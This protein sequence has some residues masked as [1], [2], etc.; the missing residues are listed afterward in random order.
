MKAFAGHTKTIVRPINRERVCGRCGAVYKTSSNNKNHCHIVPLSDYDKKVL[1]DFRAV[2]ARY[3]LKH[4]RIYQQLIGRKHLFF[5]QLAAGRHMA[6]GTKDRF[7]LILRRFIDDIQKGLYDF[8][9]TPKLWAF[10]YTVALVRRMEPRPS[11]CPQKVPG[12]GGAF[13]KGD[14]PRNWKACELSRKINGQLQTERDLEVLAR[15]ILA[16]R[17]LDGKISCG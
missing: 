7:V 4:T 2:C 5:W 15:S 16:E 12:C 14:C 3:G 9:V 1:S 11:E 6:S 10:R 8:Q 17:G 13:Y